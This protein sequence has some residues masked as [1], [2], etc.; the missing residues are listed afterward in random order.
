MNR[1]ARMT[2]WREWSRDV[3]KAARPS[4]PRCFHWITVT[5]CSRRMGRSL[6]VLLSP[7][8]I[9]LEVPREQPIGSPLRSPCFAH[10]MCL[11]NVLITEY[12]PTRTPT[13]TLRPSSHLLPLILQQAFY[14]NKATITVAR[15]LLPWPPF[16]PSTFPTGL[17]H[18]ICS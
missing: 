14:I 1:R 4:D 16:C 7:S 15:S 10:S 12:P 13:P 2:W 3:W 5:L 6:V 8:P 17:N 18:L 11:I 9:R